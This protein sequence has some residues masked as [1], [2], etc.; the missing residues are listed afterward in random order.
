MA[1]RIDDDLAL[2]F[3][4]VLLKP[5]HS[6]VLP[7]EVNV[8]T[9]LTRNIQL[10]IP[11]ISAAMDTVTEANMAVALAQDGGIGVVHKNFDIAS[12]VEQVRLVKKFE[13][14]IVRDP[15]TVSLDTK[16]SELEELRSKFQFS[17]VPVLDGD[18]LVGIITNRDTRFNTDMN[19]A[20]SELMTPREQLVTAVEGTDISEIQQMMQA[21]RIEKIILV[22]ALGKLAGIVTVRDIL[23]AQAKPNACKDAAGRLRVG[24]AVGVGA[25][26]LERAEALVAA[27]VDVIVIDTAHGHSQ[28][29]LDMVGQVRALGAGF[30]IIAGNIATAGAAEDLIAVGVDAVKVGIGPGSICTTRIIAGIGVPQLT[31]I[32]DVAEVANRHNIPV[33]ADGGIKFSGD[34]TKA[35]AAGASTVMIGSLLAA[36]D[37]SPGE[38]E[39]YQGRAYKTYRGMGSIGAMS[40]RYGSRDRYFQSQVV[41]ANKLVPEGIEGRVPYKGQA[42]GVLHQL[43]GGL[44]A[45]MGYTGSATIEDL[46]TKGEF[47]RISAAGFGESHVH[48]VMVTKEAPNYSR[49][50]I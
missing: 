3:S 40:G 11:L 36:T 19:L 12:Q 26:N 22:D 49:E 39:L 38:V 4:D 25:A 20:V 42:A 6:K 28:A 47:V 15:V 8:A 1:L 27:G 30:D 2:T 10:N 23:K 46:R 48:G 37:E 50:D 13:S 43:L 14:G 7:D 16:I 21:H 35:I 9:Q 33:I 31:A 24:A 5:Q 34:I 44:R 18:N 17:G 41:G 29:V 45:G 32:G